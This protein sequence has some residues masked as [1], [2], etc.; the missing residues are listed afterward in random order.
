MKLG[1]LKKVNL[2][3]LLRTIERDKKFFVA[4]RG[5][6]RKETFKLL[7]YAGTCHCSLIC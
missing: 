3:S 4:F 1:L 6:T 7:R 5:S 2:A